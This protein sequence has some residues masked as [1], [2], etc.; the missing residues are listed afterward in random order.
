MVARSSLYTFVHSNRLFFILF[1]NIRSLTIE[2]SNLDACQS[3]RHH[4]RNQQPH[5]HY[6]HIHY[7]HHHHRKA[8]NTT[9]VQHLNCHNNND[10]F[11]YCLHILLHQNIVFFTNTL[12]W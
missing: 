10:I 12:I 6:Y 2:F 11:L 5:H 1:F 4:Q 3:H 7:Y 9:D 8:P